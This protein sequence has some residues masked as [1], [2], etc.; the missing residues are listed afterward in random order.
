MN[1]NK[2]L[3]VY[4]PKSGRKKAEK[5]AFELHNLLLA[6]QNSVL[7]TGNDATETQALIKG[8]KEGANLLIAVGGDG[9]VNL[10]L[11][12]LVKEKITL[13]VYPAGTGNDFHRH[14][15]KKKSQIS[16]RSKEFLDF[17]SKLIDLGRV[18]FKNGSR[19]FGQVLSAGFDS[20]VNSRAN[21]LK[22][23]P[24]TLKYV[25]ALF[26]ELPSFKPI[27]YLLKIDGQNRSIEAMMVVVANGPTYGGGMKVLPS[28]ASDDGF[29]DIMILHPV[30]KFELLRVFPRVFIGSHISHPRVEIMRCKNVEISAD[31]PV[32]ADGEYFCEGEFSVTIEPKILRIM[33]QD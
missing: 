4:N 9:L 14:N 8:E 32:Y 31:V 13:Y 11:Q 15:F 17:E 12:E 29:L 2:T 5:Y 18:T 23:L 7:L 27:R 1:R 30:S 10:S 25:L 28:A 16:L 33:V 26:L 6:T 3:I 24:G 21:K 19:Y 22:Y 20:F